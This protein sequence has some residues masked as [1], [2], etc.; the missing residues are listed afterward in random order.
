MAEIVKII[1]I[2]VLSTFIYFLPTIIALRRN[3]A[4]TLSIFSMNLWGGWTIVLWLYVLL[5]ALK[6]EKKRKNQDRYFTFRR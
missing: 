2:I 6:V 3:S 4:A 5:R 1:L